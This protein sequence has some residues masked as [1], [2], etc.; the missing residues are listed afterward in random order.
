MQKF[1]EYEKEINNYITSEINIK[2]DELNK[3]IRIIN[4]YEEYYRELNLDIFDEYKN[5]NEIK[6]N[7]EITINDEP[8]PFSYFYK[9]KEKSKCIIKYIFKNNLTKTDF[10]FYGCEY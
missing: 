6:D 8:I 10:M 1:D 4:S 3:D 5:E 2:E 9:F 7:I